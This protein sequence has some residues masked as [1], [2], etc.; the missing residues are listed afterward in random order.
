MR[1]SP[2]TLAIKPGGFLRFK[3]TGRRRRTTPGRLRPLASCSLHFVRFPVLYRLRA[4]SRILAVLG[5]PWSF[6]RPVVTNAAFRVLDSL[7][8]PIISGPDGLLCWVAGILTMAISKDHYASPF[9]AAL[10]PG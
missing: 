9:S 1:C 6:Y 8:P 10:R 7:S 5:R 3:P 4:L 2:W